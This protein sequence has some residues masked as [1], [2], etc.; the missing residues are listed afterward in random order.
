MM[1]QPATG[2]CNQERKANEAL[3][4][5]VEGKNEDCTDFSC[6]NPYELERCQM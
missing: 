5:E 1:V 4:R 6:I 3:E 2:S